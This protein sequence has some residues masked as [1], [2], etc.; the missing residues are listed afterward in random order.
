MEGYSVS[1][2]KQY[3]RVFSREDCNRITEVVSGSNWYFGHGSYVSGDVRRGYPFWRIDLVKDEYFS[4]Y[5]LNI[6]E[7]KTNQKYE[8]FDVYANGHTFGTHGSFHKDWHDG[9]GRTFLFYANETWRIDWG[10]KTAFD[11][12]FWHTYFHVPQPNTAILF[13]GVIPHAAEVTS[14]SFT[15]LRITIA[16][17]LLLKNQ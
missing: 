9:R 13:P 11:F 8:L 10:G 1:D 17:K 6:I 5:L 12:G 7:E 4:K 2:I 3:E 16:W 14:R 15:G